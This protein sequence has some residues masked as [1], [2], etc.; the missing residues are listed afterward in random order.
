MASNSET[1]ARL[2]AFWITPRFG[3]LE[4]YGVVVLVVILRHFGW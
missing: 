3:R 2:Q 4:F 1:A